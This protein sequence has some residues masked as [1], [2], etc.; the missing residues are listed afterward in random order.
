MPSTPYPQEGLWQRPARL[1]SQEA[2]KGLGGGV[3][4][5]LAGFSLATIALLV[6]ADHTPRLTGPAIAAFATSASFL[7]YSMQVAF[8]ALE[9]SASPA[10]WLS[11][12]PEATVN[13][14]SLKSVRLRQAKEFARVKAVW[15]AHAITYELGFVF[16]LIGL[17]LLIWPRSPARGDPS[18]WRVLALVPVGLAILVEVWWFV[19][20]LFNAAFGEDKLPGPTPSPNVAGLRVPDLTPTEEAAALD[21]ERRSAANLN[22]P[23]LSPPRA[24]SP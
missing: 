10:D 4:P 14:R 6:T 8:Q 15:K 22:Y 17:F 24:P 5:F 23:D 20:W 21:P 13:T 16:F 19:A 9:H 11:W 7:L 12:Y 1:G 18:I 2:L 3:A